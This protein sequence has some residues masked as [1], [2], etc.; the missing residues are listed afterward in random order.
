MVRAKRCC[1][2]RARAAGLARRQRDLA[3]GCAAVQQAPML[4]D[5]GA[6][7]VPRD[8]LELAATC[9]CHRDPQRLALLYRLLW[10]IAHGERSVLTNPPMPMSCARCHGPGRPP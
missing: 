3:A 9:L 10:R 4:A 6:P 1:A 7:N 5:A 2:A 8:F